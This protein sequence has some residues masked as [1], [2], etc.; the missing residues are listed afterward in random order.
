MKEHL[1]TRTRPYT[2]A[3]LVSAAVAAGSPMLAVSQQQPPP[4]QPLAHLTTEERNRF[5]NGVEEFVQ[6][7]T[8]EEGLGPVFNG[9][10]CAECHNRPTIGGA[11]NTFV[12]RFGRYTNGQFD[13]M[14]EFGG[15]LIQVNGITTDTCSASGEVV[16]P[17]ASVSTRRETQPL[18]GLGLIDAI[19][20]QR[21]L[22]FAD[23]DDRNHDGISGRPNL[24]NG[25]VGKFGWKAQVAT[26]HE[27]AGDAYLNEMGI[28]N[29]QFPTESSPQGGPV[30]CDTVQDPEDDGSGVQAF[31]D[32]MS[33][34]APLPRAPVSGLA[35]TGRTVFRHL[36][37]QAC[38]RASM[39]TGP[40][41]VR[42]LNRRRARLFSD[43]LLHDMGPQLADGIAQGQATG[44]EFRTAPLWGVGQTPP[45]LHD[46][47][48][49]TLEAAI[50]AHGGEAQAARDLFIALPRAAQDALIAYLRTL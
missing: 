28:T 20:D 1:S 25:H 21:I 47:R 27:F 5:N 40:N 9:R 35:A 2:L 6:I 16:P 22:R 43:L 50:A 4:P 18:F 38:H 37:C 24:L 10:S 26:V 34:L 15:S 32:F 12:T 49:P 36:K 39:I 33:L 46:G 48:A 19:P 13:P 29:P 14:T 30:V 44:S 3:L 41:P 17:E 11:S 31:T 42:A 7:E 45:Y 23:P 8:I